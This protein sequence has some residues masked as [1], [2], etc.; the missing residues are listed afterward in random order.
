VAAITAIAVN[1]PLLYLFIRAAGGGFEQYRE[2][3][4]SVSTALLTMRTL[5]LVAGVLAVAVPLATLLAWLVTRTDLPARRFWATTAALPLAF[6]SYVAALTFVAAYGPRGFLQRTLEPLGVEQLPPAAYGFSGA[7]IVLALST[8]PYIFLLVAAALRTLDGAV[9]EASRS[10][11]ASRRRTFFAVILPQLW[12]ALAGGSLLV[13]L[14]TLSDFGAVSIVRYNTF[15]LA[16][17]NAYR[18]LFDRSLAAS[19]ATVLVLMTTAFIVLEMWWSKRLRPSR[20]SRGRPV[21]LVPLGRWRRPA[22]AGVAVLS[23]VT[24][25]I[26]VGVLAFWAVRALIVGNPLGDFGWAAFNSFGVATPTAVLAVALSLPIAV[27]AVRSGGLRARFTQ[28]MAYAGYALPGLV[29]GLALVFFTL[30]VVP[31]LYQTVAILVCAY[32]VRFLPEAI[33]ASRASLVA[34]APTFEEAAKALG[35]SPWRV[36]R[37]VTLPLIRPGMLAGGGLVF[38]TTMKELPATLILRPT[39]FETLATIIWSTASEGIYSQAALPALCLLAVTFPPVYLL[40]IRPG[41]G[42][43]DA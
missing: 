31:T 28:G 33:S 24:L 43:R 41:L 27:W 10:L 8:Y 20:G 11:G 15:T 12:P 37:T 30:R 5:T 9:E 29:V 32:L 23:L 3:V 19:L 21:R 2:A 36:F 14:Y 17:Y 34:L 38:L 22:L 18:A 4:F 42:E 6:P 1:L 26:P 35:G 39:G 7:L 25:W 16:I 13:V 40:I